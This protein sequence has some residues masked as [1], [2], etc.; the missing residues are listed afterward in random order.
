VARSLAGKIPLVVDGGPSQ[1]GIES[2]VVDLSARPLRVLRPGM[3]HAESLRAALRGT[4]ARLEAEAGASAAGEP[5]RSPG[6]LPK[7]YSPKAK[8]V[9]WSWRNGADLRGQ[10]ATKRWPMARCHIIAHRHIPAGLPPSAQVS[11]MA[12]DPAAFA[13]ALYAELHRCDQAGARLIVVEA[14]PDA[15]EWHGI[16]DRLRRAAGVNG[17]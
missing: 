16:N 7:H 14:V 8:L 10:L 12:H 3:I 6:R 13:R 1:V 5:L 2:T 9:I 4:K 15:P 17:R 11:V